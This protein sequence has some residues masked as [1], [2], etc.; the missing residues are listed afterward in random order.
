MPGSKEKMLVERET[1]P[2]KNSII[3]ERNPMDPDIS[4]LIDSKLL[5]ML[6]DEVV[7]KVK[8]EFELGARQETERDQALEMYIDGKVKEAMAGVFPYEPEKQL[9][10]P[11]EF[12]SRSLPEEDVSSEV[13]KIYKK[14][15]FRFAEMQFREAELMKKIENSEYVY[16]VRATIDEEVIGD[17][18]VGLEREIEDY[19][20]LRVLYIGFYDLSQMEMLM[21]R[22]VEFLWKY[23]NSYEIIYSFLQPT[24]H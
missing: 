19:K 24:N 3:L 4:K 10:K 21:L 15:I 1:S 2:L 23:E 20:A 12:T 13:V 5:T 22:F 11:I 16:F 14:S 6:K 18:V 7:R 17:I 9:K 8:A